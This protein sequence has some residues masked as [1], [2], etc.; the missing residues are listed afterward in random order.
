MS[1]GPA[2]GGRISADSLTPAAVDG[3]PARAAYSF[4]MRYF[5]DP[6]HVR[7]YVKMAEG[8]DGA[9][10][11]EVLTDHLPAGSA[12]LE[13]GMGPGKDL[14]LLE[15]H[16]RVTGSDSSQAFLDL[17]R[18][19]HPDGDLMLLDARTLETERRF[20]CLYSNKVLQHLTRE[21]LGRSFDRQTQV[22][23]SGGLVLHSF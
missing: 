11:V 1:G 5:D 20:D 2:G 17:Y 19:A 6:H 23:E 3:D 14:V 22:L 8:Y 16:Y 21:E 4:A 13:L 7:E 9:Q 15:Q 18:E 10:L 12:V